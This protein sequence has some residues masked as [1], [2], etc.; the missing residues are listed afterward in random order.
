MLVPEL[1][2]AKPYSLYAAEYT[3]LS[4]A[5]SSRLAFVTVHYESTADIVVVVGKVELNFRHHVASMQNVTRYGVGAS[6]SSTLRCICT[7]LVK[8]RR[9]MCRYTPEHRKRCNCP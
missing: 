2:A 7:V 1:L 5:L 8:V 4:A 3:Y 9:P 6:A